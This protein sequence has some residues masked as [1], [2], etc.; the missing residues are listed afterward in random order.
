MP[1]LPSPWPWKAR[2]AWYATVAGTRHKLAT[3]DEGKKVAQKR[4]AELIGNVDRPMSGAVPT[5]GEIFARYTLSLTRRRDNGEMSD[6][7]MENTRARYIGFARA[8]HALPFDQVKSHHVETWLD[9]QS[10]WGRT[11]RHDGVSAVKCG[12]RWAVRQGYI[13]HNPIESMKAPRKNRRREE[14]PS[15][16]L[17]NS[18][19]AAERSQGLR[20]LL[21]FLQD[22]GCRPGEARVLEATHIDREKG[23][24]VL[25]RHK[26]AEK[27]GRKRVIYLTGRAAEIAYRLAAGS[28]ARRHNL[29]QL[30]REGLASP[31]TRESN[32]AAA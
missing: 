28:S 25:A 26:T 15:V 32:G 21:W 8:N 14:I 3:F 7:G 22:T 9:T 5:V 19:I 27:T 29:P 1:R 24:A 17:I 13:N 11:G 4:L 31:G 18:V 20:D 10:R 2:K 12:F 6:K 23:I 30:S 16:D